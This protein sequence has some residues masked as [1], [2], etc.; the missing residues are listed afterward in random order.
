MQVVVKKPHIRVE[1]EVT[2][3]LVEYLRKSFGEI[4]VIEDEDEQRIE[5]SESDWYQT[6]R[7]TIT[8][9]ENM[10]VYRQM[11]NLTQEELGSRIGNLTRQNISNMETN[12]RSIS[13][14]V[15]K[16]LAQVFD[17]SVEKFL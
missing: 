15:A 7:K 3:S 9:G 8:P 11:H 6:I 4:E 5:I 16:K 12:R 10:R 14:A 17:V 2:E 1:G 13:K